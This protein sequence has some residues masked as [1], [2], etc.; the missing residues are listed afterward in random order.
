MADDREDDAHLDALFAEARAVRPDAGL[1]ARVTADAARVQAGTEVYR[2]TAARP[3]GRVRR[4]AAGVLP[5]IVAAI[6]GWGALSGVT[7]AGL[8]GLA[9]GFWSPEAVDRLIGGQWPSLGAAETG[10]T[11]DLAELALEDG[12]V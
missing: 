4:G 9:V 1:V 2:G 5:G 3:S 10:W 8:V 7:A 6:G 11:P 12:D